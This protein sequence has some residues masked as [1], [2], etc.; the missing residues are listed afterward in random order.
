M[1]PSDSSRGSD[2]AEQPRWQRPTP[3]RSRPRPPVHPDAGSARRATLRSP[4]MSIAPTSTAR[5]AVSGVSANASAAAASAGSDQSRC[6]RSS[7][8]TSC[9]TAVSARLDR[10]EAAGRYGVE[11][12][13]DSAAAQTRRLNS[14]SHEGRAG[15]T[16][17]RAQR[18]VA[19]QPADRS[20]ERPGVAGRNGDPGAGREQ[21]VAASPSTPSTIGRAAAIASN[22][23]DGSTVLKTPT[24]SVTSMMSLAASSDGTRVARHQAGEPHVA[25]AARRGRRRAAP[26]SSAPSPTISSRT[27]GARVAKLG[28]ASSTVAGRAPCP[29]V[30]T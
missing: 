30:P 15:L 4:G 6:T 26:R 21:R 14:R 22:I 1:S 29:I 13:R 24:A 10:A 23:F 16:H 11:Q 17:R 28:A 5:R 9:S 25:Q 19:R 8:V 3:R 18:R 7:S 27:S 12:R 20:A 2:D